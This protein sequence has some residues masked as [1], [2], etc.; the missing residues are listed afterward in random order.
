MYVFSA[1]YTMF[2]S[3]GFS[4]LV[5]TQGFKMLSVCVHVRQSYEALK[6]F[7]SVYM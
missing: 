6:C 5:P 4:I 2:Y 7:Q 3:D 1:G